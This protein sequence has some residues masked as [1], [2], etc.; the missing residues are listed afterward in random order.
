MQSEEEKNASYFWSH[1]L[2][3]QSNH[4]VVL[5]LPERQVSYFRENL[6]RER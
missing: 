5:K 1:V 6:T 4:L 3:A 2:R